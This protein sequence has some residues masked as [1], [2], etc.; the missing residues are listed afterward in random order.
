MRRR[1]F[2][3]LRGGDTAVIVGAGVRR[4]GRLRGAMTEFFD[5]KDIRKID[6][7]KLVA[8]LPGRNWWNPFSTQGQ[9][10]STILSSQR[11]L[12]DN[13]IDNALRIA[14]FIGQGLI[15]TGFLRYKEED[16]NYSAERLMEIFP[17]HFDGIAEARKYGGNPKKIAN[18]VYADRLGNGDEASGDGW[19]Y[20]GRGF[21]QLTGK[22]NYR[23]YGEIAGIDLVKDP[24]VL[25]RNLKK[26]IEVAAAYFNKVGLG[27]Y[28]DQNDIRAV[29]RGVN[30]GNPESSKPAHGEA[31]R[32][33]WTQQVLDLVRNPGKIDTA[34]EEYQESRVEMP[35]Q[36][37][38]LAVGSR[39]SEVKDVQRALN[40]LGYAAG[41]EDGVFGVNTERAV[42]NFQR[43]QGLEITGAVNLD[44]MNAL[45]D[46]LSDVRTSIPPERQAGNSTDAKRGGNREIGDARQVGNAGAAAG[47]AG[48]AGAAAE[49]GALDGVVEKGR[50]VI[51]NIGGGDETPADDAPVDDTPTDDT[52]TD[53]PAVDETLTD[54]AASPDETPV[55]ETPADDPLPPAET[56][57]DAD[58]DRSPGEPADGSTEDSGEDQPADASTADAPAPETQPE[59]QPEAPS[60]GDAS[61]TDTPSPDAPAEPPADASVDEH[62]AD[63]DAPS[64]AN[65]P[66]S[67]QSAAPEPSD[68]QAAGGKAGAVDGSADDM[69]A[70]SPDKPEEHPTA[71]APE[72]E[73]VDDDVT[74]DAQAPADDA[75]PAE[76]TPTDVEPVAPSAT[77]P[78]DAAPSTPVE[79]TPLPPAD[80]AP[81]DAAPETPRSTRPEQPKPAPQAGTETPSDR[82]TPSPVSDSEPNMTVLVVLGF[83]AVVGIYIFMRSRRVARDQ[84]D[85]WKTNRLR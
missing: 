33:V 34:S 28:A 41:A 25:T 12:L 70:S 14:H 27:S 79:E 42:V 31:D 72:A 44:T 19:K 43:D 30:R 26:S 6:F 84:M 38:G 78:P 59:T 3:D 4:R 15:E 81:T 1:G 9:Y 67:D 7:N 77:T 50:E 5:I 76:R 74:P 55:D 2:A 66:S 49:T 82:P 17:T 10:I 23:R 37:D 60:S 8:M 54:D 61:S 47:G 16:L 68:A 45:D 63:E 62:A 83:V 64:T 18:R 39:G 48:A 65:Q 35:D 22:D 32:I 40:L 85:A 11:I 24:D 75:P 53:E 13:N 56:T 57:P 20:R 58:L 80:P 69:A 51:E 29:S 46:A 73:P 21:F 36:P 52:P 71:P